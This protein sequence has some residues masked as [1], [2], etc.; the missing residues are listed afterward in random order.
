M[1]NVRTPEAA[2]LCGLLSGVTVLTLLGKLGDAAGPALVNSQPLLLLAFNANDLHCVLTSSTAALGTT[3]APSRWA[4]FLVAFVRRLAED[5][6]FFTLGWA[7]KDHPKLEWVFALLPDLLPSAPV[8]DAS[9]SGNIHLRVVAQTAWARRVSRLAVVLEPGAVVCA[10]AGAMKMPPAEF[11]FLNVCG[12]CARL[13][14]LR[15]LGAVFPG[16]LGFVLGLILRH[17]AQ[18]LALALTGAGLATAG[19]IRRVNALR[20]RK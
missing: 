13:V 5:P 6:L 14:C 19:L 9:D 1:A 12:T 18:L 20:K 7:Y 8:A 3:S 15:S 10:T 2:L 17:R 16:P 11:A 4:W